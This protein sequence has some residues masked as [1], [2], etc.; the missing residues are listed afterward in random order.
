MKY[1]DRPFNYI[2]FDHYNGN[3]FLCPWMDPTSSSIGNILT[4]DFE[5]IWH[6]QEAE[7][8]RNGFRSGNF[9]HCR[10]VACPHIQNDDLPERE[11]GGHIW[12]AS[13]FPQEI[14]LAFDFICNIACPSCRD[15]VFIPDNDYSDKMEKILHKILPIVNKAKRLTASGHGDPFASPYM[16]KVLENLHPENSDYEIMLET[17]G[18]FMDEKHWKKIEHLRDYNLSI[19]VTTNSYYEPVYSQISR[20]GNLEKLKR[21]ELFLKELREKNEVKHT[22]NGIVVQEK[23]YWEIPEFIE[24]SLNVYG[25]DHVVLKPIYNWGNLSAEEYWFK[26]V[27][28]PCHPYHEDYKR[29]IELPI[30]KDN[31]KVYNFGG[32]T[33]HEPV[34]MNSLSLTEQT[35][36]AAYAVLFRKW[37]SMDDAAER[38]N[39][40]IQEGKFRKLLIY[41]A[42]EIG[43]WTA[44]HISDKQKIAGFIDMFIQEDE[45]IGY[46]V[47]KLDKEEICQADLIIVTP[48]HVFHNIKNDLKEA[49]AVGEIVSIED[50]LDRA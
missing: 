42:A 20:G 22:T 16:M 24:K 45:I 19:V 32:E 37:L 13:A 40:Y 48:V 33:M 35:K 15:K 7:R 38:I 49:G 2:Y 9:D 6:G 10:R 25:F 39:S 41:G 17:N 4:S 21:N 5:E 12:E 23:N 18:I 36:N 28:N 14:N 30:V 43:K 44:R 29:I 27:L 46:P 31:P 50:I 8:F 1:C 11:D 3:V 26:D 34:P 47:F